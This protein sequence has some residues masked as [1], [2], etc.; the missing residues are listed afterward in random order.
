MIS[1][2]LPAGRLSQL[3]WNMALY[4]SKVG[5]TEGAIL[6]LINGPSLIAYACDDYIAIS[7]EAYPTS[8]IGTGVAKLVASLEQTKLV[9]A[10]SRKLSSEDRVIV[11]I[12]LDESLM[13]FES[14]DSYQ[15]IDVDS[16]PGDVWTDIAYI[17]DDES[18]QSIGSSAN[19]DTWAINP[20]RLKNLSR[21]K[22][23][24]DSPIDFK[25]K[26]VRVQNHTIAAWKFLMG[27]TIRGVVMPMDRDV[28]KEKGCTLW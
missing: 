3:L 17:I 5:V 22:L 10:W 24:D 15:V 1:F 11:K 18:Q 23:P 9:E 26:T 13:V 8:I 4:T 14:S 19:W 12:D 6:F 27:P 20:D 16:D 25:K 2:E 28:L 21:L 7:D